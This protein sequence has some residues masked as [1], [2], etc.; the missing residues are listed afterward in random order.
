MEKL[1]IQ[2]TVAQCC[3]DFRVFRGKNCF[4]T[5]D[6]WQSLCW[7]TM[8]RGTTIP[9]LNESFLSKFN[10]FSWYVRCKSPESIQASSQF[11]CTVQE[12]A[13]KKN[14]ISPLARWGLLDFNIALRAFSSPLFSSLLSSLRLSSLLFSSPP[15]LLASSW[16]QWAPLDHNRGS[17]KL[18]GHCWTSTSR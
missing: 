17:P 13:P 9:Y 15:R 14:D 6:S 3:I 12:Q 18:S 11:R 8:V 7:L 10:D 4:W 5:P 1:S 16:S 2:R